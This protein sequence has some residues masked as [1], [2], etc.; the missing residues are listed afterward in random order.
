MDARSIRWRAEKSRI[1]VLPSICI[2]HG[3]TE[4]EV[5]AQPKNQRNFLCVSHYVLHREPIIPPFANAVF[6]SELLQP[7]D[8]SRIIFKFICHHWQTRT[9][10]GENRSR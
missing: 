1:R 5:I 6:F 2:S 9:Y 3:I 8:L 4:S 10:Q 7:V